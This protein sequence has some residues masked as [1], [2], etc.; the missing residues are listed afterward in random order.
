MESKWNTG[1]FG[2][3]TRRTQRRNEESNT[4][5]RKTKEKT[6]QYLI[7]RFLDSCNGFGVAASIRKNGVV[8]SFGLQRL[9]ET[10]LS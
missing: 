4:M 8:S 2:L 10:I 5:P 3:R 1:R 7:Q 6:Q 9:R